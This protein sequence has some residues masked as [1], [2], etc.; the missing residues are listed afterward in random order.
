MT[1]EAGADGD[2]IKFQVKDSGIGM[3][4]EQ[5]GKVFEAFAQADSSTTRKY[6]GTGLGLAIT[7]KFC[8]MM[9]GTIRWRAS[10]ARA[11][12]LRSGSRGEPPC[13]RGARVRSFPSGSV[14][15]RG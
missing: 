6:G 5:I 2:F 10:P 12:R 9:D 3:T 14:A 4:E 11:P 15:F 8:E 7:R 13:N 1:S